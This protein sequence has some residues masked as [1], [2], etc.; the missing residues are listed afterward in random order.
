MDTLPNTRPCPLKGRDLLR[1]IAEQILFERLAVIVKQVCMAEKT[2]K[3]SVTT[4]NCTANKM[5]PDVFYVY[6]IHVYNFQCS[7]TLCI[8]LGSP[9][10]VEKTL[11]VKPFC[12]LFKSVL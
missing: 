2:T 3:K 5:F 9:S 6:Y 7:D 1:S 10:G 12:S 4:A 11:S 8:I